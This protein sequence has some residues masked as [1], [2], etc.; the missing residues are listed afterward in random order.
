MLERS[1]RY[2]AET[3]DIM[4]LFFGSYNDHQIRAVISLNDRLDEQRLEKA[5]FLIADTIPVLKSRFV[6]HPL[7]AYWAETPVDHFVSLCATDEPEQKINR[8]IT[9][10]TDECTG[11]Q[12]QLEIVRAPSTDTLCILVNHMVCD[13]AGF[14]ECL[15]LLSDT[16]AALAKDPGYKPPYNCGGRGMGQVLRAYGGCFGMLKILKAPHGM[17]KHDCGFKFPLEGDTSS[18]FIITRKLPGD[19]MRAIKSYGNALGATVNDVIL[20]AYM[21]ALHSFLG[22]NDGDRLVVPCAVD[23]RK[24]LPERRA[25]GICNLTSTIACDIELDSHDRFEETVKKV[26]RSMDA[27]KSSLSCLSGPMKLELFY[28]VLPYKFFKKFLQKV[29]INPPIFM[30]NIGII[31]RSRLDF[32]G[33]ASSV[34]ITGSVKYHPYFQLALTTFNDELTFS[35]NFYGTRN[36]RDRIEAFLSLVEGEFPE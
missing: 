3:W 17:S 19:R 24:Y 15:Y 14:K 7:R 20:A 35:V 29:F 28:R 4:Q 34:Y 5:A 27:E 6:E 30:T 12:L 8:L 10:A 16:Y 11:P 9:G 23:L 32:G 2:R 25:Q 33:P 31:D 22:L 26:K 21:R 13:A 1:N 18:P 36:D